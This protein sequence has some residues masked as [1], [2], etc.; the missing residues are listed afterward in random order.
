MLDYTSTGNGRN[1]FGLYFLTG[2]P[3]E[4]KDP[5]LYSQTGS[6]REN[7]YIDQ[8][9]VEMNAGRMSTRMAQQNIDGAIVDAGGGY[10]RI[11]DIEA[12]TD[13]DLGEFALVERDGDEIECRYRLR[14]EGGT[15]SWRDRYPSHRYLHGWD[16]ADK[17]DWAV[18]TTWDLSTT[19]FTLVEFERFNK[20][21]WDVVWA[22]I[23]ERHR[24]YGTAKA[25]KIDST[26]IGDVAENELKDIQAEGVNFSGKKDA[27]LTNLQTALSLR[28]IRWP[29]IKVLI[30]EHKF[31]E[32]DDDGLQTDCVMSCAVALWFARRRTSSVS[33]GKLSTRLR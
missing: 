5:H 7:H 27:L 30:D 1:D 32:R 4:K 3:G 10:F 20:R 6:T 14:V 31:Y 19:P 15:Q 28:E 12:A 2:L 16:L 26:G 11:E 22:Q 18:G 25:T 13:A 17:Q 8:S 21:G 9:R 24:R 23:R 33:W 29:F